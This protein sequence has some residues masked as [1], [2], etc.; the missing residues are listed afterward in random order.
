MFYYQIHQSLL[1][2]LLLS[3]SDFVIACA[4]SLLGLRIPQPSCTWQ[5]VLETCC[6][7]QTKGARLLTEL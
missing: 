2:F 4:E 1:S 3:L 7:S 5:S 6:Y